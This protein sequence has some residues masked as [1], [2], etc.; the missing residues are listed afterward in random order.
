MRTI[1]LLAPLAMAALLTLPACKKP[2][3]GADAGSGSAVAVKSD[4]SLTE[5]I[6]NDSR[7][8]TFNADLK[9]TGLNGVFS[10]KGDYTLLAP[11]E[12]AFAA[13]GEK[14]AELKAPDQK[15]VLAAVLRSHVVPGTLTTADIDKAIDANGGKAI[16]MRTMGKGSVKFARSGS[17]LTVTADDG[18]SAKLAAAGLSAKNGTV[19]PI[20]AVLKK[21]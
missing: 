8:K 10:G 16:S 11:T 4:K 19:L 13:L 12:T 14:G 21:L 17:Q 3:T 1:H 15:A 7:F 2:V 18:S 6:G 5:L 20:D 9:S